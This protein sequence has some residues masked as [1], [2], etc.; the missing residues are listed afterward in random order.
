MAHH[1]HAGIDDPPHGIGDRHPAFQL[2]GVSAPLLH[3]PARVPHRFLGVHLVGHEGQVGNHQRLLGP[4]AHHAGV[5]HHVVHGDG[6]GG[7]IAQHHHAQAV[8][9]QQDGNPGGVGDAGSSVV[10]KR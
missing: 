9:N 1:R 5:M 8:A 7:I 10:V 2:D 3:Q 4:P 6:Y